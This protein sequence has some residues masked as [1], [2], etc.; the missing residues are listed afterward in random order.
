MWYK[1]FNFCQI[2]ELLSQGS[3]ILHKIHSHSHLILDPEFAYYDDL[4]G[5]FAPSELIVQCRFSIQAQVAVA[6]EFVQNTRT[7]GQKF[8]YLT[9]I[10]VFIPHRAF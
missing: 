9:K 4:G 7:F 5:G 2:Q 1:N 6:V 10:E 3:Y 8:L